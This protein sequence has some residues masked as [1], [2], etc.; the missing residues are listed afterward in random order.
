MRPVDITLHDDAKS[1]SLDME[2][3]ETKV[4]NSVSIVE[5]ARIAHSLKI[6]K[7]KYG[8]ITEAHFCGYHFCFLSCVGSGR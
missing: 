1:V 7:E 6:E 8:E 5:D 2:R 3:V 4:L